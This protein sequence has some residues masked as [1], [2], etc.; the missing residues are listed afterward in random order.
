MVRIGR[1]ATSLLVLPSRSPRPVTAPTPIGFD[2]AAGWSL[3]G[4]GDR[5]APRAEIDADRIGLTARPAFA[6]SF[7]RGVER[8]YGPAFGRRRLRRQSQPDL[9]AARPGG[10]AWRR[11]MTYQFVAGLVQA[12]GGRVR[13]VQIDRVVEETYV[14]TVEV[15][16]PPRARPVDARPSDALNPAALV[17]A[18][19]FGPPECCRR[20]RPDARAIPPRQRVCVGRWWLRR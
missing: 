12:L 5:F 1:M 13:Q 4:D 19:I 9:V 20:R 11:P 7:P 18:P 15:E 3:L 2:H 16:G 8:P 17:A 10:I 6:P 14:A